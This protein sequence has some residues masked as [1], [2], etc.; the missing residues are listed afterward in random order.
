MGG[1]VQENDSSKKRPVRRKSA[2]ALRA[3]EELLESCRDTSAVAELDEQ[4]VSRLL[5]E[6]ADE[7]LDEDE[8][9]TEALIRTLRARP[10]IQHRYLLSALLLQ[11][12]AEQGCTWL[13]DSSWRLSVVDFLEDVLPDT[14]FSAAQATSELQTH[15]RLMRLEKAVHS[16]NNEFAKALGTQSTLEMIAA[17]QPPVMRLLNSPMYKALVEPL[18]PVDTAANL[19]ELFVHL[20]QYLQNRDSHSVVDAYGS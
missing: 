16:F 9:P 3:L 15:E 7:D 14:V 2:H 4:S 17:Q 5:L 1:I 8:K 6:A 11:L 13:H 10:P 19:R 12:L 18:L 20:R